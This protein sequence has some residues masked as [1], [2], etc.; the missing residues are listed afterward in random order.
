[1]ITLRR[2]AA[3]LSILLLLVATIAPIR[4]ELSSSPSLSLDVSN[5]VVHASINLEIIQNLTAYVGSFVL[6]QFS[7]VLKGSNS[8][9]LTTMIQK[10]IDAKNPSAAVSNLSLQ[11]RSSPWVNS[12]SNQWF[13]FSLSYDVRGVQTDR[14]GNSLIDLSWK[15]FS[16]PSNVTIGSYEVN[17]IGA[18]YMVGVASEFV[19]LSQGASGTTSPVRFTF[20][21]NGHPLLPADFPTLVKNIQILNFSS[22]NTP[23]SKWTLGYNPGNLLSWSFRGGLLG[24]EVV[25]TVTEPGGATR[26]F[27]GVFY[28]LVAELR[29][30]ARSTASGDSLTVAFNDTAETLMGIIILSVSALGV[31]TYFS[32]R[33]LMSAFGKKR[34]RR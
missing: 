28:R 7:G 13:N 24:A 2:A 27:Y 1:M 9:S 31:V 4:A 25:T 19:A 6:P 30:P 17:N 16:V 22:I 11:L 12:T 34:Q 5:G 15:A 32:E 3:T 21:V 14:P 23:V 20:L 29:S 18:S 10:A 26:A 8:S 33:R